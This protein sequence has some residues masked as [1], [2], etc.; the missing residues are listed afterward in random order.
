MSVMRTKGVR[1]GM[2][3][4]VSTDRCGRCGKAHSGQVISR[5]R[6]GLYVVCGE[7]RERMR[8][9]VLERVVDGAKVP[10]MRNLLYPTEW[11]MD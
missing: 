7:T 4:R 9:T 6:S 3:I 11:K 8:V 1:S 5:D 2:S 10:E